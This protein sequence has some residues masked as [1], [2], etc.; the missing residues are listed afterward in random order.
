VDEITSDFSPWTGDGYDYSGFEPLCPVWKLEEARITAWVESE[1]DRLGLNDCRLI[2]MKD[3]DWNVEEP[4]FDPGSTTIL[5][6]GY[7]LDPHEEDLFAGKWRRMINNYQ[8]KQDKL[9]SQP[10]LG[11]LD[12]WQEVSGI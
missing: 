9:R 6:F 7:G 3:S 2:P 10:K 4:P 5:P 11:T 8:H 12:W 1:R